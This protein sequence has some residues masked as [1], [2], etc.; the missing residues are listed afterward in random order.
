MGEF[1]SSPPAANALVNVVTGETPALPRVTIYIDELDM[2]SRPQVEPSATDREVWVDPLPDDGE[3]EEWLQAFGEVDEVARLC[4]P[5]Q[6]ELGEKGYVLFK[7]HE[8]AKKCVEM[9][10]GTWSESERALASQ[11]SF[12]RC[13]VRTYPESVV[14]AFL[15]KKGEDINK[16]RKECGIY[17]L[18]LKGQDL[19]PNSSKK[20]TQEIMPGES[21][22]ISQ[23]LHF[24]A[25]GST[26]ALE[27]LKVMLE[28]RLASIHNDIW[29]KVE[30]MGD[31]WKEAQDRQF[32]KHRQQEHGQQDDRQQD[33]KG[34]RKRRRRD[35]SS[36]WGNR[37]RQ[38]DWRWSGGP[39]QWRPVGEVDHGAVTAGGTA[40]STLGDFDEYDETQVLSLRPPSP[41]RHSH[42]GRAARDEYMPTVRPRPS[43]RPS[44][45]PHVVGNY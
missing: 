28:C 7:E 37:G 14:S 27:R 12:R 24:Y 13:A 22:A 17:K 10:A 9:Q 45:A 21:D 19:S 1:S 41:P 18:V 26:E 20:P 40:M 35:N 8:A 44:A 3:V 16:L 33:E 29:K 4:G 23:R 32:A 6:D 36:Q 30:E 38:T 31:K 2:P 11:V 5:E 39:D 25:E 43:A 34:Q 42:H 15:G